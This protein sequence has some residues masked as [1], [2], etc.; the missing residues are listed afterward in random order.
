MCV[1][2]TTVHMP[3][4]F[5]S[6]SKL[7][8]FLQLYPLALIKWNTHIP[9][10]VTQLSFEAMLK[11]LVSL[12]TSI[13][14]YGTQRTEST[15]YGHICRCCCST[16]NASQ[17][18]KLNQLGTNSQHLGW[19]TWHEQCRTLLP[20]SPTPRT[21]NAETRAASFHCSPSSKPRAVLA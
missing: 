15:L 13:K 10:Q 6:I 11:H 20:R 21:N 17:L 9:C 7:R 12:K 4:A 16:Q 1:Q 3:V 14:S 2:S 18:N 5:N 19:Y 8:N